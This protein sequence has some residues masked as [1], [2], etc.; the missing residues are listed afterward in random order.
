MDHCPSS[1]EAETAAP[2]LSKDIQTAMQAE[3]ALQ[4][5]AVQNYEDTADLRELEEV[6]KKQALHVQKMLEDIQKRRSDVMQK[7]AN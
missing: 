6:I 7:I 5:I 2:K 4:S 1:L 3:A